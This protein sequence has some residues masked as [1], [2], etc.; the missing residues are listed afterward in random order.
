MKEEIIFKKLNDY[1]L[2]C[3]TNHEFIHEIDAVSIYN[4]FLIYSNIAVTNPK[5]TIIMLDQIAA[6]MTMDEKLFIELL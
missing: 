6:L 4:K 5:T 1:I 2:K 3:R